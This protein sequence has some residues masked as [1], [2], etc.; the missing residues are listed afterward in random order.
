MDWVS[1]VQFGKANS[2][3][4]AT[5]LKLPNGIASHDTF[6][7]VFQILDSKVLEQMCIEFNST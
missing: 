1:V 3:W 2:D 4:F 6:A 5:F 7:R